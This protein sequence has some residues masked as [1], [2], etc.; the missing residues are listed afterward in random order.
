MP[1]YAYIGLG[2]NQ[3]CASASASSVSAI[4]AGSAAAAI[5]V[6][7]IV[8]MLVVVILRNRRNENQQQGPYNF[9]SMIA[10]AAKNLMIT[11]KST[12]PTEYKREMVLSSY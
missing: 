7:L 5:A 3:T 6:I 11:S 8:L 10:E 1:G 4:I 2:G 9:E 12:A